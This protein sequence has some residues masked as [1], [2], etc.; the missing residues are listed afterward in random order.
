MNVDG[1]LMIPTED[2]DESEL[3]IDYNAAFWFPFEKINLGCGFAGRFLATESNLNFGERT[4][5]QLGFAGNYDFGNF[6]PGIHFRTPLDKDLTDV[7]NYAYG[8]SLTF[9]IE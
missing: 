1:A 4:M 7:L 2:G 5:H 6:K 9:M 8:F 3:C